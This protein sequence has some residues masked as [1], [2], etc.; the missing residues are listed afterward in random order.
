M[1]GGHHED[2]RR[3]I[4]GKGIGQEELYEGNS[5]INVSNVLYAFM[6]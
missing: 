4:R 5:G 1:E 3:I 6:K 2:R